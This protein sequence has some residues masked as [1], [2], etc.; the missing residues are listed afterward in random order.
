[1]NRDL[2][3]NAYARGILH[4]SFSTTPTPDVIL[5]VSNV[6]RSKFQTSEGL[7]LPNLTQEIRNPTFAVTSG[8]IVSSN[9]W[10]LW[11]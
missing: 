11:K 5:R 7:S 8:S 3:A 10:L 9:L 6:Q 2:F 4:L 1:M